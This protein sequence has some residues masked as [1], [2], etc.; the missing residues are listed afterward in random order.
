MSILSLLIIHNF[1]YY[2]ISEYSLNTL[3]SLL[4]RWFRI[5]LLIENY[6]MDRFKDFYDYYFKFISLFVIIYAFFKGRN[7][8]KHQKRDELAIFFL[9]TNRNKLYHNFMIEFTIELALILI[10]ILIFSYIGLAIYLNTYYG[11]VLL[12]CLMLYSVSFF[13]FLFGILFW[14]MGKTPSHIASAIL[15]VVT[16]LMSYLKVGLNDP[17]WGL[18]SVVEVFDLSGTIYFIALILYLVLDIILY[19]SN[20]LVYTKS[21][22]NQV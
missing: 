5:A 16:I 20:Y 11:Y 12:Q 17:V 13:T 1:Y 10:P 15:L 9:R 18:F 19:I 2:D 21:D 6:N 4:P 7:I 14:Q 8:G 3:L 22:T